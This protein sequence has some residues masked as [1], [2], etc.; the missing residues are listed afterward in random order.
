[1]TPYIAE[2]GVTVDAGYLHK[3]I[4]LVK[5]RCT[6]L[7]EFWEQGHFFFTTPEITEL[8]A[9]KDKWNEQKKAFFETWM[10]G[11]DSA[12]WA[13]DALEANFNE[14]VTAQGLKKGD[15]M[16]PLR[17]MLV[18]GKYGPH[19]FNIVEMIGKE[20]TKKRIENALNL[21]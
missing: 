6:L 18:G 7:P 2:K 15:V 11:L 21:L 4:D 17:I 19:V 8:Q 9:I 1:V 12:I 10:A 20:E 16:L 14:L 13:H 5:E 3:V